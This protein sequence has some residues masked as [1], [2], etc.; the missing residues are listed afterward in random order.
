MEVR[1]QLAERSL[2]CGPP[3]ESLLA[4]ELSPNALSGGYVA[5]VAALTPPN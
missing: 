4:L 5:Y 3:A 2:D 1:R